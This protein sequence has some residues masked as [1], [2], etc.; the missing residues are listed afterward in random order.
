MAATTEGS[1][2]VPEGKRRIDRINRPEFV[3]GLDALDLAELRERRDECREELEHLSMLRRYVQGRAE[4]LK[5]EIARRSGAGDGSLLDNL[6]EILASDDRAA[7]SRGAAIRLH[8]PDDEMLLA[9][10]RVERIVAESGLT[11]PASL[12]DEDLERAV[13]ELA[14][15]ERAVSADRAEVIRVMDVLQDELKRRFKEDPA[16]VLA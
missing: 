5:G 14:S 1:V 12:S 2:S 10:R 9:R 7:T 8:V 15:E 11:D 13:G 3:D 16:S 4:I 6:A